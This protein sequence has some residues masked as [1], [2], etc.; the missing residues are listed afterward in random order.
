MAQNAGPAEQEEKIR[1]LSADVETLIANNARLQKRISELSEEL[2]KVREEQSKAAN[3]S[4]VQS[5]REDVRKLAEKIQ[6]VDKKRVED[7]EVVAGELGKIEKSLKSGL[8]SSGGNST[9]KPVKVES[10]PTPDKPEKGY[11]YEVQSGDTLSTIVAAYNIA[12]KEKSMKTITLKQVMD[13][14]KDVNWN[15]LQIGQK[16]FIPMPAQ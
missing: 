1:R 13:A 16:I 11:E 12:F 6:E 4:S 2:A 15:R 9:R 3:D 7:K 10:N 8:A 5:L 14:N